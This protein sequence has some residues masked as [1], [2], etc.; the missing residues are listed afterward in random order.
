MTLSLANC[1]SLDPGHILH[2][3][4]TELQTA[5]KEKLKLRQSFV[6]AV[7]KLLHNISELSNN[8]KENQLIKQYKQNPAHIYLD[9]GITEVVEQARVCFFIEGIPKKCFFLTNVCYRINQF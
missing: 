1:S 7:W 6:P 9:S 4:L 3:K 2:G 8:Q 5:S